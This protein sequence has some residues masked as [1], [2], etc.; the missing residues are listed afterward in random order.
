MNRNKS[1]ESAVPNAVE[2]L[3]AALGSWQSVGYAANGAAM[4]IE[5]DELRFELEGDVHF[6]GVLGISEEVRGKYNSVTCTGYIVTDAS[7]ED[8]AELQD[9]VKLTSPSMDNI[10]NAIQVETNLVSVRR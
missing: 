7:D 9:R 6:R 5:V 4:G 2:R 3:L 8:L 1:W 10:A